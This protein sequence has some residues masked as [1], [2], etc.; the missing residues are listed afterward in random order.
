ME[1]LYGKLNSVGVS[2]LVMGILTVIFAIGVGTVMII[3]GGRLLA[4]KKDIIF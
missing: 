4:G 2:S 3:N 1:K